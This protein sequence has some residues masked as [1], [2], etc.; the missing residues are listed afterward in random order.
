[1]L[2]SGAVPRQ[3][4]DRI[5]PLHY[6]LYALDISAGALK[7]GLD[8][9]DPYY[10]IVA[11]DPTTFVQ[12]AEVVERAFCDGLA[13]LDAFILGRRMPPRGFLTPKEMRPSLPSTAPRPRIV[14]SKNFRLPPRAFRGQSVLDS[15]L[16]SEP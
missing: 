2:Y 5:E 6:L 13:A 4:S 10:E 12:A 11:N 15:G 3:V 8:R 9:T 16:S 14:F 7:D 1:M